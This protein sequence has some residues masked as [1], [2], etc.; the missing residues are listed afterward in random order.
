MA[1]EFFA[2]YFPDFHYKYFTCHSWLLD[3]TLDELLPDTSNLLSFKARFDRV[4][5]DKDYMLLRYI[6]KWN[7]NE[8]NL[9]FA[10]PIS[11]FAAKVKKRVMSG[12]DFYIT[13]GILK[14]SN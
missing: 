10:M 9:R 11:D 12:G 1:K 2:K 5:R 8:T 3:D 7:T 13:Y 4:D 6:F 14:C